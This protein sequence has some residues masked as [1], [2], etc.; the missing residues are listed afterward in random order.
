M[1]TY[2]IPALWL[3]LTPKTLT[4]DIQL[5]VFLGI[6]KRDSGSKS[7]Q[8]KP[9]DERVLAKALG[10][11]SAVIRDMSAGCRI[12]PPSNPSPLPPISSFTLALNQQL[13]S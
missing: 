11:C 6:L 8:K 3:T 9:V 12:T 1:Q 4:L 5:Q 2:P 10:A 13:L 7:S